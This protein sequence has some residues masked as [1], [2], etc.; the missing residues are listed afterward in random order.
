MIEFWR[1]VRGRGRTTQTRRLWHKR[2]ECCAIRMPCHIYCRPSGGDD[3]L[4]NLGRAQQTRL[5]AHT[6]CGQGSNAITVRLLLRPIVDPCRHTRL[7]LKLMEETAGHDGGEPDPGQ[8]GRARKHAGTHEIPEPGTL[9]KRGFFW[10]LS[11]FYA[12]T[13]STPGWRA[14]E[15]RVCMCPCF[16]H[17]PMRRRRPCC[18]APTGIAPETCCRGVSTSAPVRPRV[19]CAPQ[20]LFSCSVLFSTSARLSNVERARS[21][22]QTGPHT[23]LATTA[24]A[25]HQRGQ[26]H[27]FPAPVPVLSLGLSFASP[28]PVRLECRGTGGDRD[29]AWQSRLNHRGGDL[30]RLADGMDAMSCTTSVEDLAICVSP[31]PA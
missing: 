13:A 1:F 15:K 22:V 23:T 31:S 27:A 11:R 6:P 3:A 25:S 4:K 20:H 9:G 26:P 16:P 2:G 10:A 24:A 28:N 14:A 19:C 5:G 12:W 30:V 17:S 8:P 29:T 21:Q 18:L 7:G